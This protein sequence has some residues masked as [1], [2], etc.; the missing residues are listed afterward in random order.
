[1]L[2]LWDRVVKANICFLDVVSMLVERVW[3]GLTCWSIWQSSESHHIY[4]VP[5]FWT[6]IMVLTTLNSKLWNNTLLLWRH[7]TILQTLNLIICSLNF[8]KLKLSRLCWFQEKFCRNWTASNMITDEA[9]ILTKLNWLWYWCR[10]VA[11]TIKQENRRLCSRIIANFK[12]I[13]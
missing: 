10:H 12:V 13:S 5:C 11:A 8:G 7:F 2:R 1:M 9:R 6:Q 4:L 3:E